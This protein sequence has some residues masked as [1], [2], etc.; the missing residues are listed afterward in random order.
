V[1]YLINFLYIHFNQSINHS[2]F[3]KRHKSRANRRRV[4]INNEQWYHLILLV[5]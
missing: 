3:A 4:P 1:I 5:G 2:I